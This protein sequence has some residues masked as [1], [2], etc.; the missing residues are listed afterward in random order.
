MSENEYL[1]NV[2]SNLPKFADW[3]EKYKEFYSD[4]F[5]VFP[6][7]SLLTLFIVIICF[8][9]RQSNKNKKPLPPDS[10]FMLI[11]IIL[12]IGV[13]GSA[14]NKAKEDRT[15]RNLDNQTITLLE[16]RGLSIDVNKI[17]KWAYDNLV[18]YGYLTY[19]DIYRGFLD[20]EKDK[21]RLSEQFWQNNRQKQLEQMKNW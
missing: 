11:A 14:I 8:E 1:F 12:F 3:L 16:L 9:K 2:V 7:L 18:D 17:P 13:A 6:F 19:V 21:K 10:L 15:A 4:S 5:P 20:S